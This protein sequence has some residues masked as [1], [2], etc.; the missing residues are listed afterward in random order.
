MIRLQIHASIGLN[1]HPPG[2]ILQDCLDQL[3]HPFPQKWFPACKCHIFYA[4]FTDPGKD[5]FFCQPFT[6]TSRLIC[7]AGITIA[8]LKIAALKP[9]KSGKLS[10]PSAL[11]VDA[12]K[13]LYNLIG[14]HSHT[15]SVSSSV[16]R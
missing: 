2:W 12:D 15:A 14:T 10:C 7:P 11:S 13:F 9:D 1:L 6:L 16:S 5:L 8:A 3:L 4:C